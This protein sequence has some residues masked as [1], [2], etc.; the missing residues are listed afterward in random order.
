MTWLPT[1]VIKITI[2]MWII[3]LKLK[4]FGMKALQSVL[5]IIIFDSLFTILNVKTSVWHSV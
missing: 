3:I 4:G 5:T 2:K 1:Y